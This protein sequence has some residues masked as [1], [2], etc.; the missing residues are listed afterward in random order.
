MFLFFAVFVFC[1]LF[2][3]PSGSESFGLA[4]LEAM[5]CGVPV[6]SSNT[7]GIPEVNVDGYSGYL[8]PVGA[9][10]EMAEKAIYILENDQ[11]LHE[12]SLQAKEQAIC[13]DKKN[14]LPLYENLYRQAIAR[15]KIG[16]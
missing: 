1:D 8:C 14:I 9:V 5:A 15:E 11:R 7:G 16:L 10:E 2:L 3:L 13:F 12:F 4:A 6:I